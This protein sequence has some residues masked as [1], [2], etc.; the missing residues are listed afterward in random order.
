[1][2]NI[3]FCF[4]ASRPNTRPV[5]V[6]GRV[7]GAIKRR[8]GRDWMISIE[9]FKPGSNGVNPLF[10]PEGYVSPYMHKTIDLAKAAVIAH[11]EG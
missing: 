2:P 7:V 9:G 6:D 11:L 4:F 3:E 8:F 5:I 1:M 10:A